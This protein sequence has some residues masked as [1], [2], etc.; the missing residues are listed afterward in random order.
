MTSPAET[1]REALLSFAVKSQSVRI[2][3]LAYIKA[4]GAEGAT[5]D[6][7]QAALHLSHQ[8]CSARVHYLSRDGLIAPLVVTR[9]T[10]AGR[11]A[12][13]WVASPAGH[14]PSPE[15]RGPTL[16]E[17]LRNVREALRGAEAEIK[18]LRAELARER[19][20]Q[21]QGVLL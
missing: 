13:V 17:Q 9:L 4:R 3:V 10:R 2:A 21:A 16:R 5:A 20:R 11:R 1:R 12:V 19:G 18:T 8:A 15:V 7:V 14:E 6:E